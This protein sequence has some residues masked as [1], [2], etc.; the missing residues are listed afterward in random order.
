MSDHLADP[1]SPFAFA[2]NRWQLQKEYCGS[3]FDVT[4]DD[5][6]ESTVSRV[7]TNSAVTLL[8]EV[9]YDTYVYTTVNVICA[10]YIAI[11]NHD[12]DL[13]MTF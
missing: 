1:Y 7:L 5:V 2:I 6:T 8:L 3:V 10:P 9:I 11:K 4:S 12:L 13:H